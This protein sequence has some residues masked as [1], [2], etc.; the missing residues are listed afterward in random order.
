MI[1]HQRNRLTAPFR[2]PANRA[3]AALGFQHVPLRST[4]L[5]ASTGGNQT[6]LRDPLSRQSPLVILLT[7]I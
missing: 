2:D 7:P 6:T 5:P 3:A 4:R 1:K